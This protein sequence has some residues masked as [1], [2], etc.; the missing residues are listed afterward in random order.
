MPLQQVD[1]PDHTGRDM[2]SCVQQSL[3]EGYAKAGGSAANARHAT[4]RLVKTV[5]SCDAL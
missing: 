1:P 5:V 3:I 4:T 2:M